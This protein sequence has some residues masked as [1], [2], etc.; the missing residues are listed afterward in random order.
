VLISGDLFNTSLPPIE[1]LKTVVTSLKKLKDNAIPVYTIA[2]SHDFSPSGKTMLDVLEE[3]DLVVNVCKGSIE[4]DKL[5][6]DFTVDEKTGAKITGMIG[7]KGMLEKKYY[8]D[9]VRENLEQEKGFKIFMFHTAISELKTEE[10]EMMEASPLSLLPRGFDY[11]AGGHVHIVKEANIEG[12]K[13][14]VYPGPVFPNS[15]AELEKLGSGGFYTYEDGKLTHEKIELCKVEKID[16]KCDHKSPAQVT[17]EAADEIRKKEL[18]DTI[19]LLRFSGKLETGKTSEI[20][21]KR[22]IELCMEKGAYFVMKNTNKLAS[23]EFDE[24]KVK[25][26]TAEEAEKLA[27]QEH[28]GQVKSLK[29]DEKKEKELIEKL[30]T[31]LDMEKEEGEKQADYETRVN[32]EMSKM[33]G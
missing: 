8:E 5:R 17:Q 31:A 1:S 32:A 23:K 9:L 2:G 20:A 30:M 13:N 14:L 21:F 19:L 24:I 26:D 7:K 12:Y 16:V 28:V 33:F 10:L 6:L 25:A 15:F 27:I 11:Y 4:D 3:A 22:I 18:K 29:L